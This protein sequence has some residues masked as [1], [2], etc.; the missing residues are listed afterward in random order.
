[1]KT[2]PFSLCTGIALLG[3]IACG[4][5]NTPASGV[6]SGGS[7]PVQTVT[8]GTG[9]SGPMFANAGTGSGLM[10]DTPPSGGSSSGT[11]SCQPG[12]TTTI[13]GVVMD[14]AGKN[15]LYNIS[16]FV[17][18]P[19]SP[20]PDLD[21]IPVSCGCS[22]LLPDKV[23]AIG[24][25][26]DA[27]GHFEIPCAP[28]GNVTL[29]VQ[30][31]KW[32]RKYENVNVVANQANVIPN[33]RLPANSSEGSLPN[34]AISTGG[35]DSF[36]CLPLRI[37]VSAS[38]YVAGSATGGHI[39]IYTGWN[40]ATPAQGAVDSNKALWDTQEHLNEHD[41]VVLSCEGQETTGGPTGSMRVG[42]QVQQ[43]MM[44]YANSGGR[45][46][47]SHYQYAWFNTGPF[48]TGGN[49][50][51]T[52]NTGM[53]QLDDT[54]SFPAEINT[55]LS[56]GAAFPEGTALAKWLGLVGA[57]TNNQLPVRYVRNNVKAL[58]QPPS[59][60]WIH[61]APSVKQAPSAAQYF[62]ADTPIGAPND[63]ICGRVVY[64]ALHVSGGPGNSVSGNAADADYPAGTATGAGGSS[65]TGTGTAGAGGRG[66]GGPGMIP[67]GQ[68]KGGIVPSGC[69]MH[70]LT[71]Q[72]LALEFMFFDLSSCLVPIGEEPPVIPK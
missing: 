23:M 38:E 40:G 19:S 63:K 60:E 7:A 46:F 9:N 30:T 1:M 22:Q 12:N 69:A 55:T 31:G 3:S 18:D 58:I 16:V 52:W 27:A 47:A 44:N 50:L 53:G 26:T 42:T 48:S 4:T 24:A 34:I 29:V 32:R 65:G 68:P 71:P 25:P 43:Y 62:S 14:P 37:G 66:F 21:K 2:L 45:V 64:S 51:A 70:A 20:L 10:L 39:H 36:E 41:V 57:L 56:A 6:S 28:S 49:N 33:L 59:T 54:Q 13:S 61:L 8:G 5:T 15:P 17:A 11:T 72:E 67:G 35:S